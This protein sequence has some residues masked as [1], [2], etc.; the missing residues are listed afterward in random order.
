MTAAIS[1][2]TLANPSLSISVPSLFPA[3][4]QESNNSSFKSIFDS[5]VNTVQGSQ[6]KADTAVQNFLNG[7]TEDVHSTALAVQRAD[8]TFQMFMQ[9]RNK[10]VSAYQEVMKM[11]V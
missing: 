8:L 9:L 2:I 1:P 10:V 6:D 7:N 4:G 3:G 5:A 11:Q